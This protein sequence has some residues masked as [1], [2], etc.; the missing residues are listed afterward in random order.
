[1][2]AIFVPDANNRFVILVAVVSGDG[3]KLTSTHETYL[4]SAETEEERKDWL[5]FIKQMLYRQ[6]GGGQ[7]ETL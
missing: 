6:N 7:T 5:R 1:L 4:M 3:E 2:F